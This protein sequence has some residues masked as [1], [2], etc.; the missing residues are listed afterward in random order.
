MDELL[1]K[2]KALRGKH[3]R[4][5][6]EAATMLSEESPDLEKVRELNDQ[7]EGIKSQMVEV[8]RTLEAYQE[9]EKEREAAEAKAAEERQAEIQRLADEKAKDMV[10]N[11]GLDRPDYTHSGQP[12]EQKP[13]LPLHMQRISVGSRF[14]HLGTLDLATRYY[15]KSR[16]A[17]MGLATAPSENFYRALMVRASEFVRQVDEVPRFDRYGSVKT[18]QL[19]AFNPH[20]FLKEQG[21]AADSWQVE[22]KEVTLND[23]VNTSGIKSLWEIGVKANELVHSTQSGYGDELGISSVVA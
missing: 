5:T 21:R 1:R 3:R 22:G 18:V 17:R 13:E 11:L 12:S 20:E 6:D 15:L 8:E 9:Q 14:D 10:K 23:N 16:A 4:V 7:A 19:P 2:L